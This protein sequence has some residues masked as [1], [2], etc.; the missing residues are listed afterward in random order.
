MLKI[1]GLDQLQ[2]KLKDLQIRAQDLKGTHKIPMSELLTP[3]FRAKCSRFRSVEEMKK[4]V[5][6]RMK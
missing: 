6:L 5:L 4:D 2:N 1:T 3:A